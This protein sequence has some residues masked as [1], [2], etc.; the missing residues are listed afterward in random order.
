ME[1][2]QNRVRYC[3]GTALLLPVDGVDARLIDFMAHILYDCDN[4]IIS[5]VEFDKGHGGE[6][7]DT[8]QALFYNKNKI[9]TSKALNFYISYNPYSITMEDAIL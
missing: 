5:A 1:L 7:V 9:D 2:W 4:G 3:L 6:N 8:V